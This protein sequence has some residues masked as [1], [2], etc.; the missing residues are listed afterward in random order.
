[1]TETA[2]TRHE[3]HP[4]LPESVEVIDC[5]LRDGEQAPGVRFSLEEKLDLATAL[6]KAGVAV[7]DAGF[8]ASSASEVEALQAMHDL[9]LNASIAATARPL[10]QDVEAA[11][12]AHA[13]EVFLFMPTSDLRLKET[14]GLTREQAT[15]CF[16]SG[17]EAAAAHGMGINLV[18]EDATRT[19]PRQLIDTAAELRR[20]VPV[21]RMVLA[22]S[23][24][25][26]HPASMERLTR[27]LDEAL[28][29]SI[30]LCAHNHNDFGLAVANTL[31]AIAGG[32]TA[33]TCTVNGI[34]ERAGNADLAECVAALTH[35]YGVEHGVDPLALPAL[36]AAVELDSGIFTSPIKPVTGF[37]V[38]RHE[39]GVHVD[40][41]LKNT[42]SYEFLPSAWVGR[43]SEFVL[44]KHSGKSLVRHVLASAGID[45]DE[46]LAAE[47]LSH[48][49][50]SMEQQDKSPQQRVHAIVVEAAHAALSGYDPQVLAARYRSRHSTDGQ[51]T[52]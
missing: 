21:R 26:A 51:V 42:C 6:S 20:H 31:A 11:A 43:C 39:S 44:G 37:N 46:D 48:V 16:R 35:L 33:M 8:P 30:A 18:F 4:N 2:T 47:A 14:L 17:A 24:G 22:D 13:D 5:T 9:N 50:T 49:K 19:D 15:T 28:D 12:R 3:F 40:S 52:P 36:S 29:H 32:A 34:G 38:F 23:V 25:C 7:L 45:C 27:I 41:M 10:R 1:M